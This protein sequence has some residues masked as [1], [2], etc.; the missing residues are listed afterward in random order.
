MEL[1]AEQTAELTPEQ[2]RQSLHKLID[3]VPDSK[4]RAVH[5]LVVELAGSPQYTLENAPYEDEELSP[6][7][8]AKLASRRAE[9]KRGE[10]VSHEEVLREVSQ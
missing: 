3:A 1:T 10:T 2:Q 5:T 7:M 9:L 4:I 6:A 8:I